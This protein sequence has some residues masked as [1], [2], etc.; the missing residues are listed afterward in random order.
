MKI[1]DLYKDI[2]NK[3]GKSFLWSMDVGELCNYIDENY[4][5]SEK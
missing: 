5:I 4:N 2:I 1:E 3:K